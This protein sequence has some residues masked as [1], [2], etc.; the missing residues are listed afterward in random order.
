[1]VHLP[2]HWELKKGDP[3]IMDQPPRP[4]DEPIINKTMRTGL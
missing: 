1:M 2:W 4:T 3:D